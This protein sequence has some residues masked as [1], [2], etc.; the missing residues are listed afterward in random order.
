MD[1]FFVLKPLKVMKKVVILGAGKVAYHLTRALLENTVNVVQ[2]FNRTLESAKTLAENF[3]IRYTNKIS[4]IE[5]ADLYIICV[6]DSAVSEASFYIPFEDCLVAHTSGSLPTSALKGKYRKGVFYPLQTFSKNR[7]L[8]YN[9]IPFFVEAEKEEDRFILE[10]IAHRISDEVHVVDYE[11]RLRLQ[12]SAVWANN[13]TNHMY[14][15]ANEICKKYGLPFDVLQPLIK[16]TAAK[17]Q[18]GLTPFE[19]QTGPARR[20]D[21]I[22]IEK[23]LELIQNSKMQQ[24][25]QLLSES[26]TQTYND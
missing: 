26:I 21:Q 9:E 6:S 14:Y 5:Q 22:T 10:K 25:Y 3:N 20:N 11:K 24:V 18:D 13:F 15:L 23:H 19:A 7:A 8:E 12:M 4:E 2:I 1:S 16:E 17:V